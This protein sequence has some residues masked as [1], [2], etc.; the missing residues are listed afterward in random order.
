MFTTDF[1]LFTENV[2]LKKFLD[3]VITLFEND[4]IQETI[5]GNTVNNHIIYECGSCYEIR[6]KD[7]DMYFY[8]KG[9][10]LYIDDFFIN[11]CDKQDLLEFFNA[12]H[13]ETTKEGIAVRNIQYIDSNFIDVIKLIAKAL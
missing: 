3:E 10:S 13:L 5:I 7:I 6:Y 8:N 1:T 9:L 12:N 4:Y 11:T 2:V